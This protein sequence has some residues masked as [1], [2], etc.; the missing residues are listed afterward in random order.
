[1]IFVELSK[2]IAK[3]GKISEDDLK[4]DSQMVRMFYLFAF[5][6]QGVFNP[7]CAFMGA[8]VA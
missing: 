3:E 2:T 5:Q 7:L 1:M 6:C 8:L 4:D